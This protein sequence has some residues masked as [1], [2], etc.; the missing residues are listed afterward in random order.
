MPGLT[1]LIQ[2]SGAGPRGLPGFMRMTFV[3]R[4]DE[5]GLLAA[6]FWAA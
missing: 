3:R 4:A 6:I 1:W 5:R 2:G